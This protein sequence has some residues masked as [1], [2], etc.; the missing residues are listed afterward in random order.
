VQAVTKFLKGKKVAG[1]EV[2]GFPDSPKPWGGFCFYFLCS[3]ATAYAKYP[4]D[5]NWLFDP[6][7]KPRVN[8]PAFVRAIQDVI[9]VLPY[10]PA[11][12]INA[13]PGTTEFQRPDLL[14]PS[15]CPLIDAQHAAPGRRL[16]VIQYRVGH[17]LGNTRLAQS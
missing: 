10:E 11:D 5:K 14:R 8:N 17:C 12:Q 1:K 7:M 2:F 3:R 9:D 15:A 16:P 6:D 13:D 4:G